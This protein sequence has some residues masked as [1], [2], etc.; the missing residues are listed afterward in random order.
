MVAHVLRLRLAM[1]LG[2]LRGDRR[3][4]I[5]RIIGVVVLIA[6]T[7]VAARSASGMADADTLTVAVVT[8][9]AGSAGDPRVR[10]RSAR[11]GIRRPSR[12][13][14]ASPS[15]ALSRVLWPGPCCWPVFSACPCS[16]CSCS[17]S[18]SR[19][20]GA[21]TAPTPS[22]A[23]SRSCWALATCVLF[24]RVSMALGAL[25][26][27]PAPVA[28][29]HGCVPRRDPRRRR[30]GRGVP[31]IPRMAR[32]RAVA[33][34]LGGRD[35]RLDAHRRRVGQSPS[36]P[37]RSRGRQPRR[38]RPHRGA[39]HARLVR[40]RRRLAH[41]HARRRVAVRERGAWAGSPCSPEPPEAPSPPA[42]SRTG[43]RDRRYLVNLVIVPI[44]AVVS[45][46]PLLVA[47]VPFELAVLLPVPIMA[48]FFGWLP[49]NDLAYDSTALWMHIASGMRG[50]SRPHRA[51]RA[52]VADQ[53]P[54]AGRHAACARD[55]RARPLGGVPSHG[56]GVCAALFLAGLGLSSISSVLAPYAVSRPATARSSSRSAQD[57]AGS[58][59]RA[60][61]WPERSSPRFLRGGSHLAGDRGQNH[62]LDVRAVDRR[63]GP[64]RSC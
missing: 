28:R 64:V 31:R 2:A 38:R 60:S 9:L 43:L 37:R 59:R 52:G 35:P 29:A 36:R 11:H 32:S 12:S 48:L 19:S 54:G 15:S 58:W 62:R 24:A 47:G 14:G 39:A 63:L 13:E 33:A 30:A 46:V 26:Q 17:A 53:H 50:A 49:H 44:A 21:R 1:M 3:D 7:V 23:S 27:R 41:H 42:A 61:S 20:R 16:S 5:R 22:R 6:A 55:R 4:V 25:V 57:P 40:P 18:A 34:G 8:V 10:G 45:M 51:S 56:R